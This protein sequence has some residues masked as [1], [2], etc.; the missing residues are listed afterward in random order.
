M[1]AIIFH[2]LRQAECGM[3][4]AV[5][6]SCQV[7]LLT[8]PG[9]AKYG[10]PEYYWAIVQAAQDRYPQAKVTA[11]LNCGN[12]SALAQ[13]ALHIGWRQLVLLG[14]V[15]ARNKVKQIARAYG[16]EVLARPPKAFDP[17]PDVLEIVDLCRSILA[18][19]LFTKL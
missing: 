1:S 11:L 5:D 12:D 7:T 17:G 18:G 16:G 10:G 19:S 3:E 6:F 14:R 15:G 2:N 4:A 8:P 9:A 13:M